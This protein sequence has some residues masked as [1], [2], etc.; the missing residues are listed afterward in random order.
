MPKI[1]I[2]YRRADDDAI[3][4]RIRDKLAVHYGDDSV[5]MDID[6][7]PFGVDFRKHINDVLQEGEVVIAVMGP[8]WIGP[9]G[10][11]KARIWDAGDPVRIEVETTLKRGIPVVP[12]LVNG[13]EM[14]K[15]T[16]LPDAIRDLAFH[17]AAL[18]D[19]GRD[20][21]Q[22]MDRLIQS[23]DRG[24]G[25]RTRGPVRR[26]GAKQ[27]LGWLLGL[28]MAGA[29]VVIAGGGWFVMTQR[30][31]PPVSAP[32]PTET[33][34]ASIDTPS[35]AAGPGEQ[36]VAS[37]ETGNSPAAAPVAE[38]PEPS[39]PAPAKADLPAIDA[40]S[41]GG[42]EKTAVVGGIADAAAEAAPHLVV[43][44]LHTPTSIVPAAPT[45]GAIAALPPPVA[46][47]RT[48]AEPAAKVKT[49]DT[50]VL[51]GRDPLAPKV[52]S[53]VSAIP[54]ERFSLCGRS[55]TLKIS[56]L[57]PGIYLHPEGLLQ[58]PIRVKESDPTKITDACELTVTNIVDGVAPIVEMQYRA[59]IP[60]K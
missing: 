2:S 36:A 6:N 52:G 29:V 18:I 51:S 9:V 56:S 42:S 39:T 3:V 19:S 5:F 43:P 26:R 14:P 44:D 59:V 11:A 27:G 58:M 22:H 7:I 37:S 33:K 41:S 47:A 8:R 50:F 13:A 23:L 35:A 28:A 21:H 10:G 24:L 34:S 49:N 38:A 57:E 1:V 60:D 54:G 40:A 12:V 30:T 55:Y 53:F 17:N 15:P 46:A 25:Y 32:Q 20:F 45:G 31:S 4:G 16:D 48:A